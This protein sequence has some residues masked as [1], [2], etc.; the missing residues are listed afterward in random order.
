MNKAKISNDLG[1]LSISKRKQL[2]KVKEEE[3]LKRIK[4]RLK[5][6]YQ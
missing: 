2:E 5:G 3:E 1:Q 4:K 6:E